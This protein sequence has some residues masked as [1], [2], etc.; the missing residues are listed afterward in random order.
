M[1]KFKLKVHEL[2]SMMNK[3]NSFMELSGDFNQQYFHLDCR[4]N[5]HLSVV[6]DDGRKRSQSF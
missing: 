6:E 4:K 1:T 2:Q 5:D 3:Q